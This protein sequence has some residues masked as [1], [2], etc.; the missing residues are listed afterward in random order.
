MGYL[1]GKKGD[2]MDLKWKEKTTK[3][4]NRDMNQM[5]KREVLQALAEAT[6]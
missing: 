4:G 5:R 6:D 3:I 2:K 1:I